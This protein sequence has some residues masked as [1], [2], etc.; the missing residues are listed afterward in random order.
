[1]TSRKLFFVKLNVYT[2]VATTKLLNAS[3]VTALDFQLSN[4]NSF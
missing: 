4:A 3:M 1:M 2:S